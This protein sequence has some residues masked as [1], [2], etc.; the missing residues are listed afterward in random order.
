MGPERQDYYT[1]RV[2]QWVLSLPIPLRL[3]LR[4][5]RREWG[6][7]VSLARVY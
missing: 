3:L 2:R 6:L 1:Q 7:I 5:I 4:K